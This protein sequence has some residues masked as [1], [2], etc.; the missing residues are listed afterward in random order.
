MAQ[1]LKRGEEEL[2]MSALNFEVKEVGEEDGT[3]TLLFVGSDETPDRDGD[4]IEVNGWDLKNYKNNPVFLWAHDYRFPPIGRS[5]KTWKEDGTLKFEIEFP[6]EGI[7]PFADLIY[8]M[9]KLKF[10]TATSVGFKPIKY[11][12]RDDEAVADLEEWRRGVRFKK[13]ELLELSAVPV[14]SNPNALLQAKSAGFITEEESTSLMDFVNG[15]MGDIN[16]AYK[17]IQGVYKSLAQPETEP[18]TE[19]EQKAAELDNTT[20]KEPEANPTKNA[21][22]ALPV[23]VSEEVKRLN[24]W[25]CPHCTH[26]IGE[27]SLFNDGEHFYHMPCKDVGPIILPEEE[28]PIKGPYCRVDH[29]AG[30]ITIDGKSFTFAFLRAFNPEEHIKAGATLSKKN[31]TALEGAVAA[32]KEVLDSAGSAAE[33]PSKEDDEKSSEGV[34]QKDG[35]PQ[36]TEPEEPTATGDPEPDDDEE[37]VL[38]LADEDDA[39]VPETENTDSIDLDSDKAKQLIVEAIRSQIAQATGRI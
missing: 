31:K 6:P 19:P 12:R 38:E 35:E 17:G 10:M 8:N 33:E 13:Q 34:Q 26:T 18:E 21:K 37:V 5:R 29:D 15:K 28:Q 3:R 11:E 22:E 23:S 7:F 1:V 20:P 27:K 16:L 39:T 32:I 2:K 25:K 24:V 9:Y 36:G 14:P 30:M 4:I